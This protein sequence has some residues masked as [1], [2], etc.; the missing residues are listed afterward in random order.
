M[1]TKKFSSVNTKPLPDAVSTVSNNPMEKH[2]SSVRDFSKDGYSSSEILAR[3]CQEKNTDGV[4]GYSLSIHTEILNNQK[5]WDS[6]VEEYK[7][8]AEAWW[9]SQARQ[10]V[11]GER[12]GDKLDYATWISVMKNHFG[13]QDKTEIKHVIEAEER[14]IL[15][16]Y[17]SSDGLAA[18]E[19]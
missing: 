11:V 4:W 9:L 5:V 2:R 14:D 12:G 19:N 13:W 15:E 7:I 8:F 16:R 1:R 18:S 17:V 3:I 6:L 10:H